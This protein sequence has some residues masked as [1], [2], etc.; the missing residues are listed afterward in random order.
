MF[1]ML[2]EEEEKNLGVATLTH[3]RKSN[4]IT[5]IPVH[6]LKNKL[7]YPHFNTISR[8]KKDELTISCT[9]NCVNKNETRKAS[10]IHKAKKNLCARFW[11]EPWIG[12]DQSTLY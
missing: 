4:R 3:M 2:E 6:S 10:E 11:V 5:P 1:A 12:A 7:L 8:H 9:H